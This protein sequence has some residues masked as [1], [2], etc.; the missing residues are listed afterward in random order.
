MQR[1]QYGLAKP[2]GDWK[3]N[4]GIP[5][6]APAHEML[7]WKHQGLQDTTPFKGLSTQQFSS[8]NV[9]RKWRTVSTTKPDPTPVSSRD[10]ANVD[11]AKGLEGTPRKESL[12]MIDIKQ[13]LEGSFS[14]T[15]CP[16]YKG[17]YE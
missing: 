13:N 8:P 1:K 11:S 12:G 6:V 7:T 5:Y 14:Q 9:V 10:K 15:S 3:H 16:S 2:R 17:S 4:D